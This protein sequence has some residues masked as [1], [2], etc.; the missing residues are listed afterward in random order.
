VKRVGR[1]FDRLISRENLLAAVW[2]ASRGR[3]Q[4]L[5]V[6][7]FQNALDD[8]LNEIASAI[9][10]ETLQF[11]PYQEFEVRDTKTR[12]IRAPSFRDRVI[13]HAL[14][15]VVGPVLERGAIHHSYAC[16]LG[17][18]QHA[19]LRQAR[20]WTRRGDWYGKIDVRKYYDSVDHEI[21]R[22]KL[23]RRFRECRLLRLFDRLLA[24]WTVTANKGLPI[25]AL[26][27][28][29]LANF[30][31]DEF[32]VRMKAS[33]LCH[34]YL[35]YMDDI[36]V[37]Q[38]E[39]L[40]SDVR[41][42]ATGVLGDLR[43]EMKHGGEWN[44]ALRGIPFLGFVIYPDRIRLG[45]MARRRLGRKYASA[46]R[47]FQDGGLTESQFQETCTALFAHAEFG[48]DLAWRQS[49]LLRQPL[50]ESLG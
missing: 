8:N 42:Y 26:T 49:L 28:Q 34:R 33:G 9:E 18:G 6:T 23:S 10:N 50:S 48:D 17:R 21:L 36:V 11:Q 25:G 24:S 39:P 31:L 38:D 27:S 47:D 30:Y 1:L 22:G 20:R 29:Y 32:D 44:R 35:R 43:L 19:A 40:L 45:R 14:I 12:Q 7:R 4:Q 5:D 13:H 41:A 16:R 2:R 37:W 15:G 46:R 3:Q